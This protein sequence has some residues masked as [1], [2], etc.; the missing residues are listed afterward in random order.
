MFLLLLTLLTTALPAANVGAQAE[1]GLDGLTATS[2]H[3]VLLPSADG[4]RVAETI[5][6]TNT[7]SANG[8]EAILP[9]FVGA[10][11]VELLDGFDG[12]TTLRGDGALRVSAPIP[13][14]EERTFS[15]AYLLP[16]PEPPLALSRPIIHPT[17]Q[18]AVML[19]AEADWTV[20]GEGLGY[21]GPAGFAGLHVEVWRAA[22]IAPVMEWVL[23][24][25][26]RDAP[27]LA[28]QAAGVPVIDHNT[29]YQGAW[30]PIAVG[31]AILALWAA[32][33]WLHRNRRRR[34]G[35]VGWDVRVEDVAAL[36]ERRREQWALQIVQ[37]GVRLER[38]YRQ[39]QIAEHVYRDERQALLRAWKHLHLAGEVGGD[40]R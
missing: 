33:S 10:G 25:Q 3:I 22:N 35:G 20:L 12:V 18:L 16:P 5:R 27:P 13:P 6:L 21:A 24:M 8:V 4:L 9:M 19:T 14:H 34:F 23:G 30:R 36:D 28:E 40:T 2:H 17:D 38:A 26:L 37:A 15:Y 1:V 11:Q 7:G 39:G 31:Y 32:V 29:S